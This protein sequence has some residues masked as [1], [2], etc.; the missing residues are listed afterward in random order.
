MIIKKTDADSIKITAECLKNKKIVIVPTDTVYGFSGIVPETESK[1][2]QIKGRAE[3]KPFIQLIAEP[4]D[5]YKYTDCV[6]PKRI[7]NLWPDSIT[8][9]VEVKPEFRINGQSTVAFR[10]PKDEWLR[11]VIKEAEFPLFST[12]VNKSGCPILDKE[13]EIEQIFG[14]EADLIV[15]DGDKINSVPSTIVKIDGETVTVI[16]QG[17]VKVN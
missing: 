7:Y 1:I 6:I 13:S 10:C 15:L 4:S 17:T 8:V 3:T 2:R 5:V 12:S 11:K 9:I 16:R 14:I